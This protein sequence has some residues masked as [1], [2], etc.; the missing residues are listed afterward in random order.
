MRAA[1]RGFLAWLD[2][3]FPERVVI[4]QAS[5][6]ELKAQVDALSK[7]NNHESRLKHLEAEVNKFNLHMGFGG[8]LPKVQ[9]GGFQR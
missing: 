6:N 7:G 5:F 2:H 1:L 8:T 9:A 4:T 3:R